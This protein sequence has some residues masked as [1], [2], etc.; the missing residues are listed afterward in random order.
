FLR[1]YLSKMQFMQPPVDV[2]PVTGQDLQPFPE[3]NRILPRQRIIGMQARLATEKGVEYLIEAMPEVLQKYPTARVL[4]QSQYLY[5]IAEEQYAK[6]L[7][8]MIEKLGEHWSFLGLLSP[9]EQSAF[10]HSSEVMVLP[11]INSTESFG[12]AQVEAMTCGTPAV[13][14]DLPGV[15][16]P[17]RE[18]GMGKVI[19]PRDSHALAQAI[20][21]VLDRPG[22]FTGDANA[23]RKHFSPETVAR[24]YE[25]NFKELISSK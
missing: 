2:P 16:C 6:M 19:P 3:K 21:E 14:S 22:E 24:E 10:F 18:T 8:P 12:M 20:I 25:A 17:V 7:V 5:V 15:R 11:S 9:L 13:A 4:H 23:I 1:R